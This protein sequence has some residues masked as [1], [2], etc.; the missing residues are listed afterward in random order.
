MYIHVY[1]TNKGDKITIY[2]LYYNIYIAILSPLSIHF[3][4]RRHVSARLRKT[5]FALGLK[6]TS[7]HRNT[8]ENPAS[9][10]LCRVVR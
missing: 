1:I 5:N 9:F 3:E 7:S 8:V 4:E 2:K 10:D 6:H